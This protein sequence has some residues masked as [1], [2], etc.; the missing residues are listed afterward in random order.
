MRGNPPGGPMTTETENPLLAALGHAVRRAALRPDQAAALPAGLRRGHGRPARR[1]RPHRRRSRRAGDLRQHHRGARKVR[2]AARPG[3]AGLLRP[4]IGRT[5]ATRSRRSN[6]RSRRCSPAIRN[7][8]YL[9]GALFARI[10][11]LWEARDRLGLD[12]EQ[13]R[14]LERYHTIFA[15]AGAGLDEAGKR[16]LAEINETLADARHA[17]RP[18]RARRRGGVD[19]GARRRRRSCRPARMGCGAAAAQAAEDRGLPANTSSPWPGRASSRSCSSRPGA[20]FA[21]RPSRRGCQR[22]ETGGDTDNRAL[23][24]EMIRLRHERARLLG[25]KLRAFQ[26]R[27]RDGEDAGGGGGRCSTTVWRPAARRAGGGGGGPAER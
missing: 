3:G 2:H 8:I 16:G 20:T 22:G 23:I 26:P 13:R 27:R 17:V 19:A 18:E 21:R 1:R 9:N 6:A 10:A 24:A 15:R 7:E 11:K 5:P 14:L 12:A 25:R 4:A